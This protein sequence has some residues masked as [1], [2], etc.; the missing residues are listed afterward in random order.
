[1]SVSPEQ[2]C[3][4][5]I[6]HSQKDSKGYIPCIAIECEGGYYKTDWHWDCDYEDAW[7]LAQSKNMDLGLTDEDVEYIIMTSMFPNMDYDFALL[8]A[9]KSV[10]V[11]DYTHPVIY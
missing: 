9:K 5:F 3:C 8:W 6:S 1:M 2:R 7:T 10:N 4:Y 11:S